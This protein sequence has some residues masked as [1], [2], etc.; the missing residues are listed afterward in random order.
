M[1]HFLIKLL[2][3]ANTDFQK[4]LRH[5][6]INEGRLT[7]DLTR[8][9][10]GFKTGNARNPALSPHIPC[11]IEDAWLIASIDYQAASVRSG[12]I[13][14]ALLSDD[15]MARMLDLKLRPLQE[16]VR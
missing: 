6:E 14:L 15:E 5:F 2:E 9:M 12:H 11:M 13:L 4:I 8:A 1:E 3:L 7:A 10:E 16:D